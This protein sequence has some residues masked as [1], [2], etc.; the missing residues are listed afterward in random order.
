MLPSSI[1]KVSGRGILSEYVIV[2][3]SVAYLYALTV[4][5]FLNIVWL[6]TFFKH[7]IQSGGLSKQAMASNILV[8]D[9]IS[10]REVVD[11]LSACSGAV[12]TIELNK[13]QT[14]IENDISSLNH[15]VHK[16]EKKGIEEE[17]AEVGRTQLTCY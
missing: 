2:M 3:T 4:I 1:S 6:L 17:R 13:R 11:K 7:E 16:H 8:Q 15:K 9:I 14:K 5:I 12:N 10:T